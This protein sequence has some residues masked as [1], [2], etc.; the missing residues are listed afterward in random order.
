MKHPR[1]ASLEVQSE[2]DLQGEYL[3]SDNIGVEVLAPL[4]LNELE[5]WA[6][7]YERV[8]VC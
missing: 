3:A 7:M 1:D 5:L 8:K 4:Q 2:G 6:I